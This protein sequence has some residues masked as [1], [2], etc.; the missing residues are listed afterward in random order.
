MGTLDMRREDIRRYNKQFVESAKLRGVLCKFYQVE[1]ETFTDLADKH[2]RYKA[3]IS[4][5]IFF[6][7][8]PKT[9]LLERLGWLVEGDKEVPKLVYLPVLDPELNLLTVSQGAKIDLFY[10]SLNKTVT[11]MVE[12]VRGP[13]QLTYYI[14]KLTP[15]REEMIPNNAEPGNTWLGDF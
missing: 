7:E 1:E 2:Y 10:H 15:F 11:F 8:N 13:L 5:H 14:A 4:M 12:D 6:D 3:P 9:R